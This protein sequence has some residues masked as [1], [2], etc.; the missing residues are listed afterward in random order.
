MAIKN[1]AV[2]G[3][4]FAAKVIALSLKINNPQSNPIL[5][6]NNESFRTQIISN[7]YLPVAEQYSFP[8]LFFKHCNISVAEIFTQTKS[9]VGHGISFEGIIENEIILPARMTQLQFSLLNYYC[10]KYDFLKF[11]ST[12]RKYQAF[13]EYLLQKNKNILDVLTI[14]PYDLYKNND[15]LY[16]LTGK[17]LTEGSAGPLWFRMPGCYDLDNLAL[18]LDNKISELGLDIITDNIVDGSTEILP[19]LDGKNKKNITQITTSSQSFNVDLVINTGINNLFFNNFIESDKE[20]TTTNPTIIFSGYEDEQIDFLEPAIYNNQLLDN[21]F[22][23]ILKYQDYA[24][25]ISFSNNVNNINTLQNN[26]LI[27]D[28]NHSNYIEFNLEKLGLNPIF[29]EELVAANIYIDTIVS[30]INSS[31]IDPANLYQYIDSLQHKWENFNKNLKKFSFYLLQDN[32]LQGYGI[33]NN[34]PDTLKTNFNDKVPSFSTDFNNEITFGNS[35]DKDPNSVIDYI[36]LAAQLGNI[37]AFDFDF[38]SSNVFDRLA[39]YLEINV[40]ENFYFNGY[41]TFDEFLNLLILE[42]PNYGNV[43]QITSKNG[44]YFETYIEHVPF[45]RLRASNN[46]I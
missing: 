11:D 45:K 6:T 26:F 3:N 8:S 4:T 42:T 21:K 37:T 25:K 16:H 20:L 43:G 41:F 18:L 13:I 33:F 27:N 40:K 36:I 34:T 24:K 10:T 17:F 1:I 14:F 2:L 30:T 19:V 44:E 28:L 46:A 12:E 32:N 9:T 38:S 22:V 15:N 31:I 5:F 7:Q 23:K 39:L 29:N 35:Y